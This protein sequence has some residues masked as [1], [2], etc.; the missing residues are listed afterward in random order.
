MNTLPW[1]V[2]CDN[3]KSALFIERNCRRSLA[4]IEHNFATTCCAKVLLCF[5]Q[6]R[7]A[8]AMALMIRTGEQSEELACSRF[9][10]CKG[11]DVSRDVS[12]PCH[13]LAIAHGF[14]D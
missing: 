1:D 8:V 3:R 7:H 9:H 6:E 12:D 13:K 11:H 14:R 5:P 4:S 10:H 2:D